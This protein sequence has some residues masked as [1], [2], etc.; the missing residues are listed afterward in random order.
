MVGILLLPK[1]IE[2]QCVKRLQNRQDNGIV[3]MIMAPRNAHA[4]YVN[5][6]V[7][8]DGRGDDVHFEATL[9]EHLEALYT[10]WGYSLDVRMHRFSF[11]AAS[12][13]DAHAQTTHVSAMIDLL[14]ATDVFYFAGVFKV[15]QMWKES[16]SPG[17]YSYCLIYLLRA[18]VQYNSVAFIGVCGGAV[19]SMSSN[20]YG[21]TPLDLLQGARLRYD[22]CSAGTIPVT[23]VDGEFQMTSGCAI[24]VYIWQDDCRAVSFPVVKNHRQWWD[25]ASKNSAALN[26]A[27]VQKALSP[28]KYKVIATGES[29][30]FSLSGYSYMRSVGYW[31][32]V[33]APSLADYRLMAQRLRAA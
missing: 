12:P 31:Q 21:L 9:K 7:C 8:Q 18:L 29:W 4:S 23:T 28:S 5:V 2:A 32:H 11:V 27:L 10:H 16:T 3:E 26:D 33:R 24:A 13:R 25:F 1:T 22:A 14:L 19:I 20:D 17:G 15:S 30:W 6:V